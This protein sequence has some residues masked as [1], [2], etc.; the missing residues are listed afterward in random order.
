MTELQKIG[1]SIKCFPKKE[2]SDRECHAMNYRSNSS[3][4]HEEPVYRIGVAKQPEEWK[5]LLVGA[6]F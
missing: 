2:I 1:V 6:G 4:G 5:W 3:Q